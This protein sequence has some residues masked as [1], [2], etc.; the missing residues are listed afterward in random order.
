[1]VDNNPVLVRSGV[2]IFPTLKFQTVLS[3]MPKAVVNSGAVPHICNGADVMAP[4]IVQFEG[5]FSKGNM[6]VVIDENHRKPIAIVVAL[7]DIKTA[8]TLK[9]G[10]ILKNIHYVGDKLW[11][12]IKMVN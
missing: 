8:E 7:Y 2:D 5:V 9:R 12:A 3:Q 4:G 11:K 1:F 10:K 6:V